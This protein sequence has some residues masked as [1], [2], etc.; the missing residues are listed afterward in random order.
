MLFA[1]HL[2]REVVATERF[3]RW[4]EAD[5]LEDALKIGERLAS[6]A[7]HDCPDDNYETDADCGDWSVHDHETL[8]PEFIPP[9]A[10]DDIITAASLGPA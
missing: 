3:T 9:G 6:D 8:T 5:T 10:E 7:N 1:I 4:V 2:E